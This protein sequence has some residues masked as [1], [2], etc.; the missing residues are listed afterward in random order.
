M[1][2]IFLF[3]FY[4]PFLFH[5]ERLSSIERF[6]WTGGG[7]GTRARGPEEMKFPRQLRIELIVVRKNEAMLGFVL[8]RRLSFARGIEETLEL[9][10]QEGRKSGAAGG[11]GSEASR[12]GTAAERVCINSFPRNP[13]RGTRRIFD[14]MKNGGRIMIDQGKP[15]CARNETCN[16]RFERN[17][18][19]RSGDV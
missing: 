15:G 14:Y 5:A 9:R 4:V 19:P 17:T 7:E 18:R 2:V 8:D 1:S 16:E 12:K 13:F 10:I 6:I 11:G 3:L